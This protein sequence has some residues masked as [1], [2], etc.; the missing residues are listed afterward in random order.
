MPRI[1]L[2]G[3]IAVAGSW[4][5]WAK[6]QFKLLSE[7]LGDRRIGSKRYTLSDG[8][9]VVM[10]I[11]FNQELIIISSP[12]KGAGFI[13]LHVGDSILKTAQHERKYYDLQGRELSKR[14]AD[15]DLKDD[16][17]YGANV[18]ISSPEA[19]EDPDLYTYNYEFYKEDV[20]VGIAHTDHGIDAKL[21]K[22]RSVRYVLNQV[23]ED[24]MYTALSQ[25][26]FS[27]AVTPDIL[28]MASSL[29]DAPLKVAQNKPWIMRY[30][31]N[32]I[33]SSHIIWD[34]II[35]NVFRFKTLFSDNFH[36]NP[37][38]VSRMY[39][40][41]F[42][43][44]GERKYTAIDTG[45]V[46][47]PIAA[48]ANYYSDKRMKQDI[49]R[50]VDFVYNSRDYIHPFQ[51]EVYN[52]DT[53]LKESVGLAYDRP[54]TDIYH[55]WRQFV[56][57]GSNN[58]QH[59]HEIYDDVII[60]F[61]M[62]EGGKLTYVRFR[63]TSDASSFDDM[64]QINTGV[65]LADELVEESGLVT[66]EREFDNLSTPA[67]HRIL[68]M[69]YR[70]I[71]TLHGKKFDAVL[72][73]KTAYVS[74][75]VNDFV[76]SA[77]TFKSGA[78]RFQTIDVTTKTTF[79]IKV[80]GGD[81]FDL[82][83]KFNCIE[84]KLAVPSNG[85][86]GTLT[87]NSKMANSWCDTIDSISVNITRCF[88]S[89]GNNTLLIALDAYP[90]SW[91]HDPA[92]YDQGGAIYFLYA[93]YHTAGAPAFPPESDGVYDFPD[94][95]KFYMFDLNGKMKKEL[96]DKIPLTARVNGMCLIEN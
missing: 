61:A 30:I 80:N 68:P 7:R 56:L 49:I 20:G 2:E 96:S 73:S 51:P 16:G 31:D 90:C 82:P 84:K 29:L 27:G 76:V 70:I 34:D 45:A 72:Y 10:S 23:I 95:R 18:S 43:P 78:N 65:Y 81:I 62:K 42:D 57:D 83:Y 50:G 33:I 21:Q 5:A 87:A 88:M 22:G 59:Y 41:P 24:E 85:L 79:H 12:F 28:T 47:S 26:F 36:D 6:S 94:A 86:G 91:S 74:H 14:P 53:Q 67:Y 32:G 54:K 8:T 40:T 60:P 15:W 4:L 39:Y 25:S 64:N 13:I 52:L 48:V 66:T 58:I 19:H 37:P 38:V 17:K 71:Q 89:E 3:N 92:A 93:D 69:R 44:E 11:C 46:V 35:N 55:Q 75:E 63:K 9:L 77:N 1:R